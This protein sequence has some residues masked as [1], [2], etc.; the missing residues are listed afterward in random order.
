MYKDH[1][2]ASLRLGSQRKSPRVC[3][4]PGDGLT[5]TSFH[6]RFTTMSDNL[7]T[8]FN[9]N[10]LL[11]LCAPQPIGPPDGGLVD[12]HEEDYYDGST[13][14]GQYHT[15]QGNDPALGFTAP[16]SF[17]HGGYDA[18]PDDVYAPI[19]PA[20][21]SEATGQQYYPHDQAYSALDQPASVPNYVFGFA[22]PQPNVPNQPLLGLATIEPTLTQMT[23]GQNPELFHPALG[24]PSA[25][26]SQFPAPQSVA[27][28]AYPAPVLNLFEP[29]VQVTGQAQV[30]QGPRP[31]WECPSGVHHEFD[32]KPSNCNRH[33]NACNNIKGYQCTECGMER[34]TKDQVVVHYIWNHMKVSRDSY[35][36]ASRAERRKLRAEV[37]QYVK[38]LKTS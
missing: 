20:L 35:S 22:Y 31:N 2:S 12:Y 27:P 23:P 25:G 18:Q 14:A 29:E 4:C 15:A 32:P 19:A 38:D 26:P 34:V 16:A 33:W 9:V 37:N 10:G 36:R 24:M 30:V 5:G 3:D 28:V 21:L 1:C 17:V 11:R 7:P 8:H 13:E 6:L